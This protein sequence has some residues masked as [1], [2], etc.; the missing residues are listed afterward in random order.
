MPIAT[1]EEIVAELRAGRMVILVDEEDRENEGDLVLATD[2]VTPEAI[3]FMVKHARGLVCL[4]LTEEHCDRLDLS[5]MSTRNGTQFGTNFTVSIE[6]AEG[7]TTGISA[8]DRART[9]QV[10]AAKDAVPADIVQPGHIFPLRAQ[11]G[12]VLMRAG[13]TE[14]GCDLTQMAGLTPAAVICEILKDDGTMA[15]LPDLLEFA[16][17][18][19]LKIGTIADLI[20]YRSQHES[21]IERVAEREMHTVHGSFKAIAY[22]DTPSGGA[23]LALVHGD[24]RPGE[25]TLVRV[26]Q[27]VSIL[28][29]L[30]TKAT[31]HSWNMASAMAAIKA[32]PSGVVVLLN[33]EESA[34]QMFA[35]FAALNN[36]QAAKP[37]RADRLDLRTYGIGAQILK[38]LG[39]CKMQLLAS[40]RKMPSMTGFNLEVTGYRAK[41]DA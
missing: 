18:H 14:A 5:M 15:R 13:H 2:F 22:R 17:E 27:P 31:T 23:H 35:Q 40:P 4:T 29:L 28:D 33:C 24:I 6:A 16:E 3:N 7:V 1:T 20:H 10:A 34:D 41:P 12:G 39:V 38:D 30:E 37:A 19:K 9:I 26:H 25:E 8:A 11:K 21:I 32:A 36:V